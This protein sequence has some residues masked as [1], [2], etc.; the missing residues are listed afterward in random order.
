MGHILG[1]FRVSISL[2][3]AC[4]FQGDRVL[5]PRC[6]EAY[7][8]PWS[9][10]HVGTHWRCPLTGSVP[11]YPSTQMAA[12]SPVTLLFSQSQGCSTAPGK[13]R[14]LENSSC[15][16]TSPRSVGSSACFRSEWLQTTPSRHPPIALSALASTSHARLPRG[17]HRFPFRSLRTPEA[18]GSL[19]R[20]RP[21]SE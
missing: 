4:K 1:Q 3:A 5:L 13:L 6:Q 10:I 16:P 15:L 17:R 7:G 12:P 2:E 9:Y 19:S 8:C 20:C 18:Q 21:S 11:R 14:T